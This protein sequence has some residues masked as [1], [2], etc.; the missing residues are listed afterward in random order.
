[1]N[2]KILTLEGAELLYKSN[3][4]TINNHS[5]DISLLNEIKVDDARVTED[6]KYLYLRSNGEDVAGPFGPFSGGGGGGGS[7]SVMNLLNESGW[8]SKTFPNGAYVSA[9]FNWS[10]T[11]GGIS[12]GLGTMTLSINDE[13]VETK[14]I[15]Q[16]SFSIIISNYVSSGDNKIVVSVTDSYGAMRKIILRVNF[17]NYEITSS[18]DSGKPYKD[19]ITYTYKPVGEGDKIVHFFLDG[20]EFETRVVSTSNR[21][22]AILIPKSSDKYP[23]GFSWH[24]MH[25]FK[26]YFEVDLGSDLVTSNTL[27]Y[28]LI[29]YDEDNSTPIITSTFD[30]SSEVMQYSNVVI[31]YYVFNADSSYSE[32]DLYIDGEIISSLPK[33]PQ[34]L[35]TWTRRVSDVGD[36]VFS[37]KSGET[38]RSFNV[39]VKKLEVEVKAETL[40]LALHL[41][42]E[43]RGNEESEESRRTWEYENPDTHEVIRAEFNDKFS[44]GTTD[45][46]LKDDDG[47]PFLR[48]KD[49]DKVTIPYYP[50]SVDKKDNIQQ[51]G[52]TFEFEF[53]VS[54]I[55]DYDADVIS[56]Y[57]GDNKVGISITAQKAQIA[58][59]ISH[60]SSQYKEDEH[61]RVSFVI[62]QLGTERFIYCYINGI[63]SGI[64]QYST[65]ESFIQDPA[66]HISLGSKD[67][68]LDVYRIRMYQKAL[69]RFQMVNNWIA[70][71]QNSEDLLKYY[72][73]NNVYDSEDKIS[74]DKIISATDGV[75]RSLPYLVI[76]TDTTTDKKGNL[77]GHLPTYKGE[78]LL[79]N[80]YY[81]NPVDKYTSFSW[82]NGEIDVQ[83]TS[84][85]AYPIKNFKLKIKKSDNYG[86]EKQ[87][88]TDC[89]GF[90]MTQASLD[91][92]KEVAFKKYSMRGWSDYSKLDLEKLKYKG[93]KS[94]P[95]NTFVFKADYASSEGANNVELVRYYND[96]C[97]KNVYATPA[98][99]G[100][101]EE[102]DPSYRE[103]GDTVRQGIDG[104]PMVW[105][106][107]E[108]NSISFIGKYNFNNHKGTEEV[109]GLDYG[110]EE[111][112]EID[113]D[114]IYNTVWGT[115]DESYEVCDNNSVLA[116]WKRV[117]GET[118]TTILVDESGKTVT[119]DQYLDGDKLETMKTK[120]LSPVYLGTYDR[121]RLGE[122]VDLNSYD[123]WLEEWRSKYSSLEEW[124]DDLR[125]TKVYDSGDTLPEEKQE[126]RNGIIDL[127]KSD[128]REEWNL[129]EETSS[130]SP[131]DDLLGTYGKGESVAH[132]YEVRFP[133]EWYDTH[134]EGRKD[135]KET[136]RVERFVDLQRWV[137]STWTDKATNEPLEKEEYGYVI[138]SA[139]YRKA[140]F[141]N[142][143]DKY[144]DVDDTTFYYIFTEAFL[145][146]DS[147]VKNSFPTYFAITHEVEAKNPFTGEQI[148]AETE[149]EAAEEGTEYFKR[150]GEGTDES[151]YV[152]TLYPVEEG[153][154]AVDDEGNPLFV[155]V[156]TREETLDSNGWPLGRW[157]WLP[158]DMDTAIGINNEGLLV[159]NYSLEDTEGLRGDEIVP[160][161][162]PS[163]VPIYNGASSVF[164]NNFRETFQDKIQKDYGTLRA[165]AFK[166]IDENGGDSIEKRYEDHQKM[167]PAAIFNEDAYYKYIKPL[168]ET[169]E[170]RLGM[171]LGSKEQQRKWWLF[172]RFRFLDSKYVAGDAVKY[173]I[174]F[175]AN[176]I[177]GDKTIKITPYIDLYVKI[178]TG[179]GWE[180]QPT[181]TYRNKSCSVYIP[182]ESFGDTEAYIYSA[183][184]IKSIEGLNK[185][186]S[187]STLD[188][189]TAVNLQNLDVSGESISNPNRTLVELD[190]GSNVLLRTIDARYCEYLGKK[191]DKFNDPSVE[192]TNCEQ[193]EE[194]Y[195]EGT[196]LKNVTLPSGGRIRSIHLPSSI[197]TLNVE[198]QYQI[199]DLQII[200]ADGTWNTSNITKLVIRNVNSYIQ[201]TAI[202]IIE[203]LP[204][205]GGSKEVTFTGFEITV[206]TQEDAVTFF[207]K[208]M[209][210]TSAT[211]EGIVHVESSD[212]MEYFNYH[213]IKESFRDTYIDC[214]VKKNVIFK[215]Y[216][217]TEILDS[218]YSV[219]A[220]EE[221]GSVV[222]KGSS[223]TKPETED[224]RYDFD[225]WSLSIDGEKEEDIL[226]NVDRDLVLYPHFNAVPKYTITFMNYDGSSQIDKQ[227]I[228]SDEKNYVDL[229]REI[230]DIPGFDVTLVGWGTD[231]YIG[232][233]VEDSE[234]HTRILNVDSNRT[235]YAQMS[236]DIK[237]NSIRIETDPNKIDYYP[238]EVFDPEGMDVKVT[239]IIPG[240][241]LEVSTIE[242]TYDEDPVDEEKTSIWVKVNENNVS[243]VSIGVG[244]SLEII[245]KPSK[246]F[247][248]VMERIE[249]D[250]MILRATFSNGDF[251]DI[252]EGYSYTPD[253]SLEVGRE[254]VS[255]S[256]KNLSTSLDVVIIRDVSS[257][258]EDNDWDLIS[259][260]TDT[261][262]ADFYWDVGDKKSITWKLGETSGL[263]NSGTYYF[264]ILGFDHNKELESPDKHTTTFGIS[265]MDFKNGYKESFLH[266]HYMDLYM[267]CSHSWN[268]GCDGRDLM[269]AIY[270]V[271]PQ[272]LKNSIKEVTKGQSDQSWEDN[273]SSWSFRYTSECKT[274][275][276]KVFLPSLC[277]LTGAPRLESG[278]TSDETTVCK[279][280]D[281]YLSKAGA[282]SQYLGKVSPYSEEPGEYWTRSFVKS[283]SANGGTSPYTYYA[284]IVSSSDETTGGLVGVSHCGDYS[285]GLQ[286][287]GIVCCFNV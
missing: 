149:D 206:P 171:C 52:A 70:D 237:D 275:K 213:E 226:S 103:G 158:Y 272:V 234:N 259:A 118:T 153:S 125:I 2:D 168:L 81:V 245:Q 129:T 258:L 179:E 185:S 173:R 82:K 265:G 264:R 121:D 31:P 133:S 191:T 218:Q 227:T 4:E 208:L 132:A 266:T 104:F 142:E 262:Q 214:K 224:F 120:T 154:P 68:V 155:K 210:L 36:H 225:G 27:E 145:M 93:P 166:Y 26:L 77:V 6:G 223:P 17:I 164:W 7:D 167:W 276:D 202:Q 242:Y 279:Q 46:W 194:A 201:Q 200:D 10:S 249:L 123:S 261:G 56:C 220:S 196:Q 271:L 11:I 112:E 203:G 277:E 76:E 219:D 250:G 85:Q 157:C 41:S 263:F 65:L 34:S 152:Y 22:D 247:F 35:Q 239:K 235:I 193:L 24:G 62:N 114:G 246:T 37:I 267:N 177:S 151:P 67:A 232:N 186:L 44:W 141:K 33:V 199:N 236:W 79:C 229:T 159:F 169:G 140:K 122:F 84:S 287:F 1:M 274:Q 94:V 18:F 160:H 59:S 190:V 256:Y 127:E 69:S 42:S 99:K 184:Q 124:I 189:S 13:V 53:R 130:I 148:Y 216:N 40:G 209:S 253:V 273:P 101:G 255:I 147:R 278:Q 217:G 172:N 162:D 25:K 19:S 51:N 285:Y 163:G 57:S 89:S 252:T 254:I 283:R 113:G 197:T 16:G 212:P 116:L 280:F 117:A 96:V 54:S 50:F 135:G 240:G 251:E 30:S 128:I 230:P 238:G 260:V 244:I 88:S 23:E 187:I 228:Y 174:S 233:N 32:V 60:L 207:D 281:Y 91:T 58:G 73:E 183:D 136:V 64:V 75:L 182:V 137:L 9:E 74:L 43:N 45:G 180:S 269:S 215:N 119:Y 83:G 80:G 175:R 39:N 3:R 192:L 48:L 61:V 97:T 161:T 268:K 211:V 95:T 241:E 78:K 63:I 49:E 92:G 195:F 286:R 38:E 284:E 86:T 181:K 138:D 204:E 243:S 20:V 109:Y 100:Y 110:G 71:M 222:Y 205:G 98:Q 28:E 87:S 178:K 221:I 146:I 72:K 8:V 257:V 131:E 248:K 176:D 21:E 105:F 156:M 12:T 55:F 231:P 150:T 270:E 139:D 134:T 188:I 102:G 66:V 106:G 111:F 126:Q 143:L 144:F 15:D 5:K 14:D 90:I 165:G 29:C 198:N 47:V 115:P 108:G 107:K 282:L 170:N